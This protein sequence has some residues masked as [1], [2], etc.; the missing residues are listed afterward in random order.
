MYYQNCSD[1]LSA[2]TFL[3]TTLLQKKNITRLQD[4]SPHC[5]T[6]TE[7]NSHTTES[8]TYGLPPFLI[9][10]NSFVTIHRPNLYTA[11]SLLSVFSFDFSVSDRK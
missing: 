2:A 1:K 10:M 11:Y 8:Y 7:P 3:R 6:I 5:P 4:C 9:I